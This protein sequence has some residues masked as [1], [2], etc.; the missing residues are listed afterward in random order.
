M[1][2]E[3]SGAGILTVDPLGGEVEVLAETL[4]LDE[5]GGIASADGN[6]IIVGSR[7]DA[8]EAIPLVIRLTSEGNP[9]VIA[10][11]D[12]SIRTQLNRPVDVAAE[13]GRIFVLDVRSR[14]AAAQDEVRIFEIASDGGTQLLTVGIEGVVNVEG[15]QPFLG[16]D[17]THG[18]I[19]VIDYA[20]GGTAGG[21]NVFDPATGLFQSITIESIVEEPSGLAVVPGAL[22]EDLPFPDAGTGTSPVTTIVVLSLGVLALVA[23]GISARRR[24][25][26][27]GS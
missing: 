9:E 13:S 3:T 12:A 23:F 5:V 14:G 6:L 21:I 4:D 10:T 24:A 15:A 26:Q 1:D 20:V 18:L 7:F 11:G 22:A 27:L 2:D 8:G 19:Y 17:V 25:A 16:I